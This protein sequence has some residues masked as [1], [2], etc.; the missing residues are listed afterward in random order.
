MSDTS[1]GGTLPAVS[2]VVPVRNEAGNIAPLIAEI[3]A[4]FDKG[5]SFEII[6]VNDGSS[7]R[8][9]SELTLLMASRPWLRRRRVSLQSSTTLLLRS[10]ARSSIE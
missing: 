7:D 9:E 4:C 2:V 6:Y 3:A 10:S 1:A 8:T 5:T